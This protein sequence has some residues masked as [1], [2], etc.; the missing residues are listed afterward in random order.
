MSCDAPFVLDR[1]ALSFVSDSEDGEPLYDDDIENMNIVLRHG[2]VDG[3]IE[4]FTA[5]L[6][7]SDAGIRDEAALCLDQIATCSSYKD[8]VVH[9]TPSSV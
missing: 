5:F 9:G 7:S 3:W 1:D 6:K 4:L 8:Q 2:Y